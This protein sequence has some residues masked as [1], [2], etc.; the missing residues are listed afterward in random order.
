MT[1]KTD[2]LT[3]KP[4]NMHKKEREYIYILFSWHLINI[5]K[6]TLCVKSMLAEAVCWVPNVV[7]RRNSTQFSDS[8]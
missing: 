7:V 4:T 3:N 2:K 5:Y 8:L 1:R 6:T